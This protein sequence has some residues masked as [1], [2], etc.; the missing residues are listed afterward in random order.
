LRPR[1]FLP[2]PRPSASPSTISGYAR[3]GITHVTLR[4]GYA[5]TPDV[6][7]ALARL[8]PQQSEGRLDLD[9][10]VC[11][12]SQV[13]LRAGSGTGMARWRFALSETGVSGPAGAW[14]N[15]PILAARR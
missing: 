8:T 9:N 1:P 10:A 5:G 11:F 6:P 7:A 3:D 4:F 14:G 2:C 15:R 12:L 13:E